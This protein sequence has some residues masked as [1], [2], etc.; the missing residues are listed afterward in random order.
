MRSIRGKSLL[1]DLLFTSVSLSHRDDARSVIVGC[2]GYENQP[3][4]QQAQSDEPL[5][6]IVET[7]ILERYARPS[8]HEFT[9]LESQTMLCEI[10]PA[11]C[12][13]PA[14]FHSRM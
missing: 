1:V 4:S 11:L 2:V 5:F 10:L 14:E 3:S 13:I 12:I 8:K 6:P 7:V 9:V